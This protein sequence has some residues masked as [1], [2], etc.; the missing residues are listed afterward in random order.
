MP[1]Q[2]DKSKKLVGFFATEEEKK[3]LKNRET[4]RILHARRFFARHC[5]GICKGEPKN[6]GSVVRC[7]RHAGKVPSA[8]NGAMGGL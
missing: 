1:S 5:R 7:Y 4:S 8:Y 2:R 6:F 3:A